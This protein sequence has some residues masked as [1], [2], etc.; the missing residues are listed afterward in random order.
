MNSVVVLEAKNCL[1]LGELTTKLAKQIL[2]IS[3]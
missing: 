1:F 2:N 3:F